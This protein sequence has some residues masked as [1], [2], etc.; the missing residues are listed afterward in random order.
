ME[1]N[2]ETRALFIEFLILFIG[3]AV[4]GILSF[5]SGNSVA[6]NGLTVDRL[7]FR[8]LLC[9]FYMEVLL[10]RL[11]GDFSLIVLRCEVKLYGSCLILAFH[12]LLKS[13]Y[14]FKA[15]HTSALTPI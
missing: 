2:K 8:H 12:H 4:Q 5:C 15:L 1:M 13:L 6:R 14:N 9:V 3:L 11:K 10:P 7:S